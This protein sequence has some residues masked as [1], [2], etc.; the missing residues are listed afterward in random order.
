MQYWENQF[1]LNRVDSPR[2]SAQ[3]LLSHV[4]GVSRLDMLLDLQKPVSTSSAQEFL[5]LADR[6]AQGEPVAYLVGEKEFYGLS[7]RVT[8]SVLIPRPETEILVDY[9]LG[10]TAAI[11]KY[12]ADIGTGSGALAVTCA[13][14][15]PGSYFVATDISR[16]ALRLAHVNAQKHGVADRIIFLE[17]NLVD[18]VQCQ[19]VDIF[20]ANLPYVPASRRTE[21]NREVIDYE[22]HGA[23]FAGEDG[24]D[25]YRELIMKLA[26]RVKRGALL[27][28]EIDFSQG[29]AVRDLFAGISLEVQVIKDQALHDR[30]AV[31]VF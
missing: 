19:E 14:Q 3:I 17:S 11:P 2:L 28:C 1:R 25:T 8:P 4:L 22:P 20:L 27:L 9:V 16:S 29:L 5:A 13:C 12:I 24:L 26:G 7:F 23:I 6:R 10:R 30:V 18:A 31:V 21:M 15:L